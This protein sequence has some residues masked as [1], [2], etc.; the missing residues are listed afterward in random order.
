M[1][2]AKAI[3]IIQI[4]QNVL[5]AVTYIGMHCGIGTT[6][7]QVAKPMQNTGIGFAQIE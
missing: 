5:K 3:R 7:N 6:T 4:S 1:P 2:R